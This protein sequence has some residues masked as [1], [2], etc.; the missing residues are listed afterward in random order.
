MAIIYQLMLG[1]L[2]LVAPHFV[3]IAI[4]LYFT[5]IKARKIYLSMLRNQQ[6]TC[7]LRRTIYPPHSYHFIG[8]SLQAIHQVRLVPVLPCHVSV[9]CRMV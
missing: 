1:K 7:L 5:V 3:S 8:G 6:N 2:I 9:Q 4:N